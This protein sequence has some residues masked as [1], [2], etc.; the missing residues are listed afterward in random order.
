MDIRTSGNGL[1]IQVA[2]NTIDLDVAKRCADDLNK[3]YPG[4]MWAVNVNNETGM[5]IVR[6]FTL[7][8]DWGF[9]LHMENVINDPANVKVLNAAGEILERYRVSRVAANDDEL[10]NL[11]IDFA[12]RYTADLAGAK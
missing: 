6:N 8:G 9:N 5:V 7:S 10:S 1:R 11:K 4:Y 3:K 12:G 2:N